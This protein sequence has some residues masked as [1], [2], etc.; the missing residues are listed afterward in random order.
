MKNTSEGLWMLKVVSDRLPLYHC[1][2]GPTA[3]ILDR[4]TLQNTGKNPPCRGSFSVTNLPNLKPVGVCSTG[5]GWRAPTT[6][7][8]V[9]SD[10]RAVLDNTS[11]HH[12]L[13]SSLAAS[14]NVVASMLGIFCCALLACHEGRGRSPAVSGIGEKTDFLTFQLNG[15]NIHQI[16]QQC[17]Q[18]NQGRGRVGSETENLRIQSINGER[19]QLDQPRTWW[20]NRRNHLRILSASSQ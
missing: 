8:Y 1:S 5:S 9:T 16:K 6:V 10:T 12:C 18:T 7:S 14:A 4:G 3:C 15:K 19:K 20:N 17:R 2:Y 11:P 13:S